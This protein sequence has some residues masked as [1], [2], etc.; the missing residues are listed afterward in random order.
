MRQGVIVKCVG[1]KQVVKTKL[2]TVVK[3]LEEEGIYCLRLW[4]GWGLMSRVHAGTEI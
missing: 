2:G 4:R 1:K 3:V